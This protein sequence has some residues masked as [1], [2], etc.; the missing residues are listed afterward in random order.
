MNV[1]SQQEVVNLYLG[2]LHMFHRLGGKE[3][4]LAGLLITEYLSYTRKLGEKD[5]LNIVFSTANR[6][7]YREELG[8]KPQQLLNLLHSLRKKNVLSGNT[9]NKQLIPV[10]EDGVVKLEYYIKIKE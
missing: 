4:S 5:A 7:K 3:L 6:I 10:M 8:I 9:I 1:K 2:A